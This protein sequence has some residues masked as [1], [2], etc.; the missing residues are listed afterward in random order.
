[1]KKE[2]FL[3]GLAT[4][5][6]DAVIFYLYPPTTSEILIG[7]GL[8]LW[9]LLVV[10]WI[11]KI[12]AQKTNK[13]ISRKFIHFT[14]GGL[15]SLLIWYTWFTGKPLFTQPTV[16]VAA[17]FALGFL[18]LAY[19]LEK[20]ELTWFQVEK[21]LGEV[22]FCL[23]WGAIY[24]LLWH[25]IPTASAATMFMAYGDGVTGVVRN[26]VYRK[27]TK[28]LWGSAAMLAVS[29]P[30]GLVLKG[31]GGAIAAIAA[32][33]IELWPKIDDNITVPIISATTMYLV[34]L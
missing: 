22:W 7:A 19:H 21:N 30:I 34:P 11:S 13:Y 10:F 6:A 17:S 24:L 16:P 20:K 12:V 27:W 2:T 31:I 5:L 8:A 32:T 15:V 28:G 1:M 33:L 18:T 26:Y 29:L 14:T 9:V 23:T 4:I 3:T 25:D